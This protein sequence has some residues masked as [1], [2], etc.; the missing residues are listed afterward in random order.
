MAITNIDELLGVQLA[1]RPVGIMLNCDNDLF[2]EY[3]ANIWKP[4]DSYAY[5][6]PVTPTI[7]PECARSTCELPGTEFIVDTSPLQVRNYNIEIPPD[8][9]LEN[10]APFFYQVANFTNNTDTQQ[11]YLTVAFK[12]TL[13]ETTTTK[14]THGCKAGVKIGYKKTVKVKVVNQKEY[15]R[16]LTLDYNYSNE[17]STT[18]TITSEF[19]VPSQ[20][21]VVPPH[22]GMRIVMS[23]A[24]GYLSSEDVMLSADFSGLYYR[25]TAPIPPLS[26][27]IYHADLYPFLKTLAQGCPTGSRWNEFVK[28]GIGLNDATASMSFRGKGLVESEFPSTVFDI[29]TEQYDLATGIV[30]S[31]T[32]KTYDGVTGILLS[33]T[34]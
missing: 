2:Y 10:L 32:T 30:T 9:I 21:V 12:K 22:K 4:N 1:D 6:W 26:P 28:Q 11:E 19:T 14:V 29:T 8:A 24:M 7:T 5:P 27:T 13:T 16:E 3:N 31:S 18:N 33:E 23:V 17:Q 20:K 25:W 15:N 34:R